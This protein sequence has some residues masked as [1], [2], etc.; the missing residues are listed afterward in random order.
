[1]VPGPVSVTLPTIL[2]LPSPE[3]QGYSRESTIA[4]KY[5]TMVSLGEINRRM[6]DFYD[7]WLLATQFSFDG[8][9]LAQAVHET[10]SWRQTA[11]Q[12]VP[13]AFTDAFAQG[14]QK[15]QQWAAF[16]ARHHLNDVSGDLYETIQMISAFLSPVTQALSDDKPFHRHWF[17]G[18]PWKSE[19]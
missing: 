9:I 16:V 7:I 8:P 14:P 10:F 15:G 19:K 6:K 3:V 4:E 1:L 18:G 17:P 12:V 11:L 5:Q 13:V 2:D